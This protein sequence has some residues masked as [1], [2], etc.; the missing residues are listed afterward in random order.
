[1]EVDLVERAPAP[2]VVERC[3]TP[4]QTTVTMRVEGTFR[5][6]DVCLRHASAYAALMEARPV[7]A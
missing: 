2:C 1:M 4:R 6:V 7:P 3:P 5:T